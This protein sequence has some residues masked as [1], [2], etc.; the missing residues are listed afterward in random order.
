SIGIV[1]RSGRDYGRVEIENTAVLGYVEGVAIEGASVDIRNSR[2]GRSDKA[3]VLYNGE[4]R[5]S[6]SRIRSSTVG[7]AAASGHAVLVNN[8]SSGVWAV[9]YAENRATVEASGNRVGS[10]YIC[11]AQFR[12]R[13]NGRYEPYWRPGQ[14][15]E[16]MYGSYP[17]NWWDAE[18]GLLGLPYQDD[19]Y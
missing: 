12:D 16:C 4:L 3:V 10:Q 14:G 8:G 17:Q 9:I 7:V 19:G 18:D 6:D 2:V 13:Y 15:W 11:R 5:L 1:I